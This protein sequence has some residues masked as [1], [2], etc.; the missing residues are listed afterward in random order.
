MGW[1][2]RK[3][4]WYLLAVLVGVPLA[5]SAAVLGIVRWERSQDEAVLAKLEALGGHGGISGRH[6]IYIHFSPGF[7]DGL[8]QRAVT[9]GG[10]RIY[11]LG[12]N[13]ATITN[14][15]AV[16]LK[17][18]S[19]VEELSLAWTQIDDAG[20]AHLAT[21]EHLEG[22]SLVGTKVCG[23]GLR[24]LTGLKK[25]QGLS[26]AHTLVDDSGLDVLAM[27][28]QLR[29][30]S[31]TGTRVTGEGLLKLRTLSKLECLLVSNMRLTEGEYERLVAVLPSDCEIRWDRPKKTD[32]AN[33]ENRSIAL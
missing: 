31:L 11:D 7:S 13:L 4:W 25:L 15:G 19:R 1:L 2:T 33:S 10:T 16:A 24:H 23:P 32:K 21:L 27:L 18:A 29:H 26:L 30:L 6:R 14:T 3:R 28:P 5:G 9:I 17:T 8:L 20:M 22:L 12:L